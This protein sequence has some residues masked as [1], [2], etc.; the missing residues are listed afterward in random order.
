M[1]TAAHSKLFCVNTSLFS[2]CKHVLAYQ[3][4]RKTWTNQSR[5]IMGLNTDIRKLQLKILWSY[6]LFLY[7]INSLTFPKIPLLPYVVKSEV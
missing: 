4:F 3:Q 5:K 2:V 6:L 7:K 1:F